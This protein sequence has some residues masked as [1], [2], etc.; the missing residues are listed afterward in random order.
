MLFTALLILNPN[1]KR[2]L[3]A[4]VIKANLVT[5]AGYTR[6][7]PV[8]KSLVVHVVINLHLGLP[9]KIGGHSLSMDRHGAVSPFII[10]LS[11]ATRALWFG[12]TSRTL[13][14]FYCGYVNL[15]FG[16]LSLRKQ[17]RQNLNQCLGIHFLATLNTRQSTVRHANLPRQTS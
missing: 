13:S 6:T 3:V 15:S 4:S 14:G 8:G 16:H 9:N 17:P 1:N 2:D 11:V 5:N 10:R 12:P 7:I